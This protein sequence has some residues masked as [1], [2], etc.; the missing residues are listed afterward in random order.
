MSDNLVYCILLN[1]IFNN[2]VNYGNRVW[3]MSEGQIKEADILMI[4]EEHQTCK[5]VMGIHDGNG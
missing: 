2:I 4:I 1:I 5:Q 3:A